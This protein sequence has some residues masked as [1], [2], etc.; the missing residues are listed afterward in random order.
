M[1]AT[2]DGWIAYGGSR[3][4]TV[5]DDDPHNAALV[6][7]MDYIAYN[8]LNRLLPGVDAG[9]LDVVEPA[10]YQAAKL[11]LGTPGFFTKAYTPGQQKV[12]TEVKGVKWTLIPGASGKAP[13]STLIESMFEPYVFDRSRP[14]FAFA[15]I[16][17]TVS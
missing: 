5:L 4:D 10:T 16:G 6:R 12:L 8:Y 9:S 3:G 13:V 2:I 15:T 7:A 17:K 1:T 14:G 11:E